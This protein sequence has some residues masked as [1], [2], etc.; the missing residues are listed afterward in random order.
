MKYSENY[1]PATPPYFDARFKSWIDALT[2]PI[3]SPS[4][5]KYNGNR[6]R[7]AP[8]VNEGCG[9]YIRYRMQDGS[10]GLFSVSRGWVT[11][12]TLDGVMDYT[13]WLQVSQDTPMPHFTTDPDLNLALTHGVNRLVNDIQNERLD[14][15][16]PLCIK[17]LLGLNQLQ[18][19]VTLGA[20]MADRYLVADN[21]QAR[22]AMDKLFESI[23]STGPDVGV[24][25]TELYLSRYCLSNTFVN[26]DAPT[27]DTLFGVI[28]LH[29]HDQNLDQFNERLTAALEVLLELPSDQWIPKRGV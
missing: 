14:R 22:I 12:Y 8:Q 21:P 3:S 29:Y 28:E 5:V 24:D 19:I 25:P 4:D 1:K 26:P 23:Q 20:S 15:V 9:P 2:S 11:P 27:Y 16:D 18:G 17:P 13:A 6:Y 10:V 7:V